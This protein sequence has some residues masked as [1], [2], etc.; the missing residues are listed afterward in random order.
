MTADYTQVMPAL[1]VPIPSSWASRDLKFCLRFL[2]QAPEVFK[3][4]AYLQFPS[5]LEQ[6]CSLPCALIAAAE[7]KRQDN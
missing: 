3:V 2:P 4:G 1:K 7:T 6:E 5:A